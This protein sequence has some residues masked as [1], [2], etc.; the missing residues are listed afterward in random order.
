MKK[1]LCA[2]LLSAAMALTC[3]AGCGGPQEEEV[4]I[5]P[6]P[7]TVEGYT[8]QQ[9]PLAVA[10]L[11]P[12]LTQILL[13][14]GYQ[15]RIVGYSSQETIPPPL[16][17]PEPVE[18]EQPPWWKFWE[19]PVEPEPEG[20]PA[21]EQVGQIGTALEPDYE[22]IGR[23]KPELIFTAVPLSQSD[24]DKLEQ[25]GIHVFVMPMPSTIEDVKERYLT[26]IR[27]MEGQA[28]ADEIGL[29]LTDAIQ[30][31]LDYIQGKVA[32]PKTFLCV[33]TL[34][35]LVVTGDTYEGALL[36][37]IG[38]NLAEDGKD[39]SLDAETLAALDPDVILYADSLTPEE[40]AASP[41]FQEKPAVLEGRIL[42]I[43][44][45]SLLNQTQ[46]VADS[47]RAIAEQLYPG[48][49]FSPPPPPPPSEDESTPDA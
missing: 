29:P 44:T 30:S 22:E 11:S 43:D 5:P 48:T 27:I 38:E 24:S 13:D 4:I 36:S 3:F 26:M 16:P 31:S 23:L 15:N 19:E 18:V 2:F 12:A 1:S 35:P 47:L 37:L 20:D 10:S 7:I 28:E 8:I 9:R 46:G 34:D 41:F 39:Y 21:P 25:V 49:D 17:E 42:A 6:Y 45:A 14:L 32:S 40:L 33:Q